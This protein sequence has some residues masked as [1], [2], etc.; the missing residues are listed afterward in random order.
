MLNK[1]VLEMERE[2]ED[3]EESVISVVV[4]RLGSRGAVLL[5]QLSN[6]F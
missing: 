5:A 3:L 4:G 2:S 1:R 6:G